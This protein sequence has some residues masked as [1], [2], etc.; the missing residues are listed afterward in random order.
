[1]PEGSPKFR[2]GSIDFA[3]TRFAQATQEIFRLISKRQTRGTAL[4]F[5]NA[6]NIALAE[7]DRKNQDWERVYGPDLTQ[8]IL[9]NSNPGITFHYF[10]GSTPETMD[11][12]QNEIKTRFPSAQ[13]VGM[14]MPTFSG[15]KRIKPAL[16][17]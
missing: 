6:Y 2:I 7:R 5:A 8:W 14:Q 10:L 17:T 4:H 3:A 12:L 16:Q 13:A 1:M 15:A 11:K 9:Y